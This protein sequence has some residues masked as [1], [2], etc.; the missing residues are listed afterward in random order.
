MTAE[1]SEQV[2]IIERTSAAESMDTLGNAILLRQPPSG[3]ARVARAVAGFGDLFFIQF[4]GI[5]T[6]W[7]W[8]FLVGSA[9]PLGL[10]L[11]LKFVVPA[12]QTSTLLY[13]ISG[14]VVVSLMLNPLFMLAGQ[15]SWARQSKAF[16]FYAG[17][18]IS[19]TALILAGI[20]VSVLFT[21]PGAVVLLILGMVT[22]HLAL[23]P[24]PLI[25]VVLL[26]SPTALAGLGTTIG[27][28][29]PNQQVSG[30]IANLLVV[31]VMFLSPIFV[32]AS[33]LPGVLQVTARLLPPTYAADALRQT[34]A[35]RVTPGVGADL[36]ILVLF[37][38][39]TMFLVTT[40]LDW[41]SR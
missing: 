11:F 41:R 33:R 23:A 39:G 17:L 4:S 12:S 26:L 3:R 7:Q 15:F 24:S 13:Y 16:D 34:L 25:V 19:R 38:A 8:F 30:V 36:L 2:G 22:F 21:L 6:A 29:A 20:S 35:G 9:L 18:P 28:L 37:A 10:L 1:T 14:N 5:R 31:T 32:P 40:R 27:V